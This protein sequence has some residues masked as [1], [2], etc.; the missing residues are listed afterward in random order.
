MDAIG[1][2]FRA[3]FPPLLL[4]AAVVAVWH[5]EVQRRGIGAFLVPG[6]LLVAET[7]WEKREALLKATA[8]TGAAA[9]AGFAASLV[10]GVLVAL[11]FSQSRAVRRAG[12]PYA[13]F[14]Q[15]V[16][17]VAV[18]PLIVLWFGAEFQSVVII[19][20]IISLFPIVTNATEGLMNVDESLVELFE[21]H[22]ATR[23]QVLLRLR[24]PHAVPD[25]V[26]GARVSSG[27]SVIGAIVGEFSAGYGN[28]NFGLGYLIVQTSGLLQTPYLF[29]AVFMSTL[30]GL[31][32]FGI[33]GS[34]GDWSTRRWRGTR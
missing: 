8:L 2:A 30:L 13:I 32:I 10:T 26:T 6:P 17:I 23:A 3:L 25:I 14:L 27:L 4:F 20:F 18:A 9:L 28:Q 22:S 11:L 12:Y 31:T 33:V 16:P 7:L 21:L 19:S 34:A 1:R 5:I 24:L 29:A 15:T